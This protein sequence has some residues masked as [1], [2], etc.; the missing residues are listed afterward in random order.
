MESITQNDHHKPI[1]NRLSNRIAE[2]FKANC[3]KT[4]LISLLNRIYIREMT[5]EEEAKI[6]DRLPKILRAIFPIDSNLLSVEID[7]LDT[8]INQLIDCILANG[9]LS[10]V[11]FT[12]GMGGSESDPTIRTPA[13]IIS[14]IKSLNNCKQL[15][16]QGLIM[17]APTCRVFKANN[18]SAKLNGLDIVR[19]A[20]N[21]TL[22]FRFLESFI[23][24]FFPQIRQFFQFEVDKPIDEKYLQFLKVH[25]EPLIGREIIKDAV[26]AVTQMG[27]KHGGN[28]GSE[29]S[30]H[31]AVAH[32]FYNGS[33]Q[34]NQENA[35][36]KQIIIDHGG[37]PQRRFNEI[38]RSILNEHCLWQKWQWNY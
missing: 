20:N 35:R 27:Y 14:V 13:Y 5:N 16:D 7:D 11:N 38:A 25:G 19:V 29:N 15:L 2:I 28:E 22:T 17:S 31:Y 8:I 18:L 1:S 4:Q 36:F 30:L 10:S 9:D 3:D 33:L 12:V 34:L 32:P 26:S 23:D 24:R 21:T 37:Q 6:N